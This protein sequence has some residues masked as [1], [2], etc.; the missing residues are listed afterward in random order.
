[1]TAA[2]ASDLSPWLSQK[3]AR[4]SFSELFVVNSHATEHTL[5][6]DG[7]TILVVDNFYA[8]PH[9]VKKLALS[10]DY[11]LE[12]GSRQHRFYPGRRAIISVEPERAAVGLINRYITHSAGYSFITRHVR[13][14]T[15]F[16][17]IDTELVDQATH[18]Q[19]VPHIDSDCTLA[20]VVYLSGETGDVSG[21]TNFYRHRATGL[22][23]LPHVP[24]P[25]VS[26]AIRSRGLNPL[27]N[28]DYSTFVK[29]LMSDGNEHIRG[30][31]LSTD[32]ETWQVT[33]RI[34]FRFNRC[35]MFPARI[36]HSPVYGDELSQRGLRLTQNFFF[37]AS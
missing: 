36:F 23:H 26:A 3:S 5:C 17:K 22:S 15:I 20:A 6:V 13:R 16:T 33:E 37:S 32:N 1:M 35:I 21:G 19:R 8:R 9:D 4:Y 24:S 30:T 12:L 28:D 34:E 7:E 31:G 25:R 2:G 18:L 27:K 10:L 14:P 11:N 29:T